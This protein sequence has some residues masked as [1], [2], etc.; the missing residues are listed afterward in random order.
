MKKAIC[1]LLLFFTLGSVY[2]FTSQDGVTSKG[3]SDNVVKAIDKVRDEV[4]LKDK[5]LI[6]IKEKVFNKLRIYG[7]SYVVRKMAHFSIYAAVGVT[8]TLVIYVFSKKIILS[9]S[10]AFL[11]TVMYAF[12]DEYRQLGIDG[13]G[14]SI[15]DVFIDS[16]GALTGIIILTVFILFCKGVKYTLPKK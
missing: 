13:R 5:Q 4:T 16:F 6:S 9:S 10:F 8:M 14:G 11:L 15:K 12:Y 7:K 1:I 2:Y 3:Q